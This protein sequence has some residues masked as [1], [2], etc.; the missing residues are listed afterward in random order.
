MVSLLLLV[1]LTAI[2]VSL[3]LAVPY[4]VE[5]GVFEKAEQVA[6]RWAAAAR[7]DAVPAVIPTSGRIDLVQLVDSHGRVVSASRMAA[8]L[9][10]LS[11]QRPPPDEGFLHLTECAPQRPCVMLMVIRANPAPDSS[12]VY[13]GMVEPW[14]L[15]TNGLN[16]AIL[17]GAA[18]IWVVV[19]WTTWG[20]VGRTLRPVAAIRARIAEIS[21]SD[22]SLRVPLPPG[23]G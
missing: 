4:W 1:I 22:L 3:H 11:R 9:P 19:A 12:V 17:S 16:Y 21:G 15:A 5:T 8:G 18:L 7:N 20:V 10:A 23:P 13:A 2:G 14:I 6:S